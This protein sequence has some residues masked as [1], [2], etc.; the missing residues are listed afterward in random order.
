MQFAQ[1]VEDLRLHRDVQRR[2]GLVEDDDVRVG[3]QR[4]RDGNP[5]ALATG[6]LVRESVQ[7]FGANP[8]LS[9]DL[10]RNRAHVPGRR[11]TLHE[12]RLSDDLPD[13]QARIERRL[14][15]L[16][17]DLHVTAALARIVID[18]VERA[19]GGFDQAHQ[20]LRQ[21]AFA[22]AGLADHAQG[23]AGAHVQVD[24]VQGVGQ[25]LGTA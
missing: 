19:R 18:P 12:Q 8:H 16:E 25:A 7:V 14:R 2:G 22:A 5:L 17:H 3:R 20:Q 15:V 21:C 9:R 4:P 11:R 23:F 24:T 13:R 6:K 10:G 1:Q